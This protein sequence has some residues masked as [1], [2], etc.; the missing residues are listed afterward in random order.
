VHIAKDITEKKKFEQQLK[1]Y[2]ERLEQKVEER[3]KEIIDAKMYLASITDSSADAII[4]V[5]LDG[6]VRSWNR[7]AELILGYTA[8]EIIGKHYYKIVPEELRDEAEEVRKE[9]FEKGFVQNYETYRLCKDGKMIPVNVTLTAIKDSDG[10][11]VGTSGVFKD[12]TEKKKLEQ[13][14]N[15]TYEKL[16]TAY[17]QLKELD[18][19][20]DEFLQNVSHELKTPLTIILGSLDLLMDEDLDNKKQELLKLYR[21][22]G[23]RLNTLVDTLLYFSKIS[24]GAE[25]LT[26][27]SLDV[28]EIV[29]DTISESRYLTDANEITIRASL[30][31]DLPSI[32]ADKDAV[33]QIF[34]N[35][36]SNAIKFNRKGGKIVVSAEQD[37]GFIKFSVSDTGIGIDKKDLERIFDRFYQVDGSVRRKY[38]GTGLGLAIVKKLVELHGGKIRVESEVGKGSKFTFTLPIFQP[39]P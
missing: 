21:K 12:L 13:E 10:N 28:D 4:S 35:L 9:V 23:W 19:M 27:E 39:Q 34:M 14:I 31:R 36:L 18:R 15:K 26:M 16:Q 32:K 17:K 6:T 3:T 20:K 1:E 30:K 11:I 7:G 33:K 24:S 2:S 37:K 8:E 38:P 29:S 22:N 5:D 25:E